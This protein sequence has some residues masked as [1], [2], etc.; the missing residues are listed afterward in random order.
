LAELHRTLLSVS[1]SGHANNQSS[2]IG[3]FR[4]SST[5]LSTLEGQAGILNLTHSFDTISW[6]L[7]HVWG[8]EAQ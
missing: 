7:D 5:Q 8:R 3:D 1:P 6:L 2:R 4:H